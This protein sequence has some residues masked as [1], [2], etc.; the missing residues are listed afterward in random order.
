MKP[1]L[2][3]SEPGVLLEDWILNPG[4]QGGS[5]P[6]TP[7]HLHPPD[8]PASKSHVLYS[9]IPSS[10]LPAAAIATS[11]G[12]RAGTWPTPSPSPPLPLPSP[13]PTLYEGM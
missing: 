6:F 12:K 2:L 9:K 11:P 4:F 5:R 3:T 7:K 8:P 10:Q 13:T 1:R